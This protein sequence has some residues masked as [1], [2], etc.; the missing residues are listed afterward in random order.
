MLYITYKKFGVLQRA[1]VNQ[2]RYQSLK[3]DTSVEN[4]QLHP[5]QNEM[6]NYFKEC[7]GQTRDT[8]QLL[9]G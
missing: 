5:S 4:L 6:E 1:I 9:L 8:K 3:N 2:Q 7:K